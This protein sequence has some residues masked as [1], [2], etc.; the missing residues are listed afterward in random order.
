MHYCIFTGLD[1]ILGDWKNGCNACARNLED[2]K[3]IG[4][5]WE[6]AQQGPF[7]VYMYNLKFKAGTRY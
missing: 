5:G 3:F 2:A 6:C 1:V 7:G 4:S